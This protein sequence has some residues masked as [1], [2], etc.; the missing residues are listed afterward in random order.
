MC[1]R[2]SSGT[3]N[4]REKLTTKM[5]G[6]FRSALYNAIGNLEMEGGGGGAAAN[7]TAQV[8]G[9]SNEGG[10]SASGGGHSSSRVNGSM[11]PTS[12]K[13]KYGYQR[14]IFLQLFSE[15]EIQVL[16]KKYYH[17]TSKTHRLCR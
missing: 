7:G 9:G 2:D 14:P 10:A 11:S 6:R 16:K 17:K 1:I 13:V 15:D 5:I 4:P 12:L 8:N 3:F